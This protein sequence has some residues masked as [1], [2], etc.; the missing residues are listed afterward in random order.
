MMGDLHVPARS[1]TLKADA[2]I[3]GYFETTVNALLP[4]R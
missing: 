2:M 3:G 4:Q 1:K